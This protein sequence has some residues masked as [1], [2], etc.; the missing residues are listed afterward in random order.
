MVHK[1]YAIIGWRVDPQMAT[2]RLDIN[3]DNAFRQGISRTHLRRIVLRTLD[4]AL[5]EQSCQLSLAICDDETIQQLNREYRGKE[6]VTDV[7][8]FST[9]HA[10]PWQGEVQQPKESYVEDTPFILPPEETNHLGEVIISLP[11][12]HRQ[13]LEP[14]N[15]FEK[16][17]ALLV[18]HGILHLLGYDHQIPE[19]RS[20]MEKKQLEALTSITNRPRSS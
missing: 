1:A 9:Q 19:E 13:A 16:E 14:N 5:P 18:V 3:I 6:E 2:R 20:A 10:G 11:Q 8:A 15:T 7:L 12:A 4:V 17:I